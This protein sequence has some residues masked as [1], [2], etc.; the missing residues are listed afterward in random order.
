MNKPLI[1]ITPSCH[2]HTY[3]VYSAYAELIANAGGTA[4][5]LPYCFNSPEILDGLILTGGAD[6][7]PDIGGYDPN[8]PNITLSGPER[9]SFEFMLCRRCYELGIPILGICRGH[10][11][12]AAA[13]GGSM[14]GDIPSE[15]FFEVHTARRTPEDYHRIVTE[16]N[17]LMQRLFTGCDKVWSTHHQAVRTA[18]DDFI[19]S[20]LSPEGVIEGIEHPDKPCLG[21]QCHPERMMF[22]PPFE[23]LVRES[24]K[25]MEKRQG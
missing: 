6:V 25:Y 4:V 24:T 15:G 10:Q 20:A 14:I 16:P 12:L 23:W 19:V 17:S 2:D 7:A 22:A 1:G 11:V 8:T 13:L 18:P 21:I 5:I 3:D 9:D